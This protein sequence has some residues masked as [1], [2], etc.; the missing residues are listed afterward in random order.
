MTY[1]GLGKYHGIDLFFISFTRYPTLTT[2]FQENSKTASAMATDFSHTTTRI[3]TQVNGS[4]AKNMGKARIY[5]QN[6]EEK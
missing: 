1:K 4:M 2:N 6:Q 3:F 5:S